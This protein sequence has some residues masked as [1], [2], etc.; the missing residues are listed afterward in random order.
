[1]VKLK[2]LNDKFKLPSNKPHNC[3][4]LSKKNNGR[5]YYRIPYY[6][7]LHTVH[8]VQELLTGSKPVFEQPEEMDQDQWFDYAHESRNGGMEKCMLIFDNSEHLFNSPYPKS[9]PTYLTETMLGWDIQVDTPNVPRGCPMCPDGVCPTMSDHSP[10]QAL[11]YLHRW[12]WGLQTYEHA[13]QYKVSYSNK[14]LFNGPVR[15]GITHQLYN[16]LH[17]VSI[18]KIFLRTIKCLVHVL[19]GVKFHRDA[20]SR[21]FEGKVT[22]KP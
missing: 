17:T 10:P 20:F 8:P 3:K 4:Y 6:T 12:Y 21:Y 5:A 13:R 1:M 7:W 18:R 2:E 14:K 22:R 11:L 9:I 15:V 16:I 19:D